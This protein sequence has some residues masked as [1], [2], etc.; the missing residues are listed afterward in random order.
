MKQLKGLLESSSIFYIFSMSNSAIGATQREQY[1]EEIIFTST[2]IAELLVLEFEKLSKI[3]NIKYWQKN[4]KARTSI[5]QLIE[6]SPF[7]TAVLSLYC[8]SKQNGTSIYF[9]Y[10]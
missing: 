5:S 9:H 6:T 2:K 10:L 3:F 4:K 1:C 8:M 7:Q